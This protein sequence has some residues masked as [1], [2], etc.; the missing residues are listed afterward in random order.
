MLRELEKKLNNRIVDFVIWWS[1]L[2]D[3]RTYIFEKLKKIG[4]DAYAHI[5]AQIDKFKEWYKD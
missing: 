3:Q 4:L 2:G 5:L 1:Y